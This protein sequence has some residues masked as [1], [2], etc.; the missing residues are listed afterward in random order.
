MEPLLEAD[1]QERE[2]SNRAAEPVPWGRLM[3]LSGGSAVP[4]MPRPEQTQGRALNE[5]T[6]GRG[7]VRYIMPCRRL[8]TTTA[9]FSFRQPRV[10]SPVFFG[11]AQV[12]A[13]QVFEVLG[14]GESYDANPIF[15]LSKGARR[16]GLL[17]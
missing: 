3:R 6:L 14:G 1:T 2:D 15:I 16:R 8:A 11:V 7:K 5:V 13:E 10:C 4:L 12:L 17:H 9:R